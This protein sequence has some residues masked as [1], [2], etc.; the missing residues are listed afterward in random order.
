[1]YKVFIEKTINLY[2]KESMEIHTMFVDIMI[3]YA[4]LLGH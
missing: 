1:M 4:V 3:H 2:W